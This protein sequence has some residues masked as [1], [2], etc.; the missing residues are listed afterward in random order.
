MSGSAVQDI[1]QILVLLFVITASVRL[2]TAPGEKKLLPVFFTF[3]MISLLLSNVYY[4]AYDVLRPDQRMPFAVNEIAECAVLLFLSAGLEGEI[5]DKAVKSVRIRRVPWRIVF[6]ALIFM[7]AHISLWIAWNGQIIE[8][9]IFGLPYIYFL[10][11]LI[12]GLKACNSFSKV[13]WGA[14]IAVNVVTIGLLIIALFEPPSIRFWIEKIC[15]ALM[16]GFLIWLFI[17]CRKCLNVSL[18]FFLF[19]FTLIVM[20]ITEG[21][22]YNF[23]SVLNTLSLPVMLM[24]VRA[25]TNTE[26]RHGQDDLC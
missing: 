18:T 5:A 16:Y 8:N 20:F 19:F 14:V 23:S 21:A 11:L 12:K 4:L 26:R 7:G 24:A 9:I 10:Y 25:G 1:I 3:A 6:I 22:F 13:E 2:M 15:Y 17:K